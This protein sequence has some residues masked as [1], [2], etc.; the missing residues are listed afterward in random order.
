MKW[1]P[2]LLLIA[3]SLFVSLPA[4]AQVNPPLSG[5]SQWLT[6]NGVVAPGQSGVVLEVTVVNSGTYPLSDIRL[7]PQN[8]SP[9]LL[10]GYS[11]GSP[12]FYVSELQ[13]GSAYSFTVTLQVSSS[14][15]QGVYNLKVSSS[16]IEDYQGVNFPASES[17]TVPVQV[18]GSVQLSA[19]SVWG[20]PSSQVEVFPGESDVPLTILIENSGTVSATN[21]TLYL[22]SHFPIYFNQSRA[23][24]GIV[25]AGG[26][27]EVQVLAG[28]YPNASVGSYYVP[29]LVHF[30]QQNVSLNATVVVGTNVK[31]AGSVFGQQWADQGEEAGPNEAGVPIQFSLMYLGTLPTLYET[32]KVYLPQG[33]TNST[34]GNYVVFTEP[35]MRSGEV[36]TLSF[37]VD[38][39]SVPLGDYQFPVQVSWVV[40]EGE[41]QVVEVNQSSSFSLF[42]EGQSQ[43]QA[44]VLNT[45]LLPGGVNN[46]TIVL[47]NSGSGPTYN[48][49]LTIQAPQGLSVLE[50]PAEI[51]DIPAHTNY[52]MEIPLYVPTSDAGEPVTL[53]I[54][55]D[56]VDPAMIQ[57]PLTLEVGL[58]VQQST[59]RQEPIL[60]SVDAQLQS[61][62]TSNVT[63]SLV[64]VN[65]SPLYNVTLAFSS[66]EVDW[67]S[68]A[69]LEYHLIPSGGLVTF[70]A[71]VTVPPGVQG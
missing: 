55:G 29:L 57:L 25:P 19:T 22:R 3:A 50:Q 30:F 36:F 64:N 47:E 63:V 16:F 60:G 12:S 21:V 46:L 51:P 43:V 14:A 42:L 40:P 38:I 1:L 61:G 65:P 2:L 56:Y 71:T 49:S 24:V 58:Y 31:V 39:G 23:I 66:S 37:P 18:I 52:S 35:S 59:L 4:L 11:N 17:F 27:S 54:S 7:T 9:L 6:S 15:H 13:P 32:V 70:N 8:S 26:Q 34:R 48:V 44:T 33:F 5:Q 10:Y 20:V 68:P 69:Q 28:V 53:T 45:S 41:G 62:S 67:L